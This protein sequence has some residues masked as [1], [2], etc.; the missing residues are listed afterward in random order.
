LTGYA[1]NYREA[2]QSGSKQ[3]QD[4]CMMAAM[5]HASNK[6]ISLLRVRILPAVLTE[7]V[8]EDE[9]SKNENQ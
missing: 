8:D 9:K 1:L 6:F 2:K 7:L 5:P 4:Q 3:T